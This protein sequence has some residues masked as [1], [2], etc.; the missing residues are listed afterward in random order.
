MNCG[1]KDRILMLQA[2]E[3]GDKPGLVAILQK[4]LQLYCSTM[5]SK[6]TYAT[7]GMCPSVNNYFLRPNVLYAFG[8]FFTI[9]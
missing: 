8:V 3:D 7:Q 2:R 4:V 5:L 6:R 1:A 9:Q